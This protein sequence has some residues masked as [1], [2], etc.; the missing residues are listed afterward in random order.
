M[1]KV[2]SLFLVC[3]CLVLSGCVLKDAAILYSERTEKDGFEIAVN[4]TG[5]TCFV[6]EY[7]CDEYTEDKEM[8]VPD[9]CG[10]IPVEQLGGFYGR[11]VAMPFHISL[12]E[13]YVNI[14]RD[15]HR[16]VGAETRF[17][18]NNND[19]IVFGI[20]KE[21]LSDIYDLL[22]EGIDNF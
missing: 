2:F 9:E 11:G 20:N 10:G 7:V 14:S 6:G 5:K 13:L 22:P 21:M 4:K 16:V 1:K 17:T 18:E 8:T 19:Y 15:D 12:E 3:V